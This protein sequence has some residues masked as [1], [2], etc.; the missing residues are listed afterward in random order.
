[1]TCLK[2]LKTSPEAEKIETFPE[3]LKIETSPHVRGHHLDCGEFDSHTFTFYNRKYCAGCSG[4]FLGALLAVLICITYYI[5]GDLGPYVFWIGVLLVFLALLQFIAI[6]I[7]NNMAK[8][9]F[10]LSLVVGSSLILVGILSVPKN[11]FVEGFFLILA[12]FWIITRISFSEKNHEKICLECRN[13]ASCT[14]FTK[15]KES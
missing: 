2:I 3:P 14:Y 6:N 4:L 9:V 13:N 8:L 7:K 15:I 11:L 5:Y 10:N 12:V 1:L